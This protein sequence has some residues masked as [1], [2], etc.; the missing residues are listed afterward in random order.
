MSRALLFDFDG[1]LAE[2]LPHHLQAWEKAFRG[3]PFEPHE[4]TIKL[5]EGSKAFQ[6]CM[7]MAKHGGVEISEEK[8]KELAD[9]K[10][11]IFRA[12]NKARLYPEIPKIIS[13]A[14]QHGAK[15][16]LVTGTSLK[17]LQV[18]IPPEIYNLFDTIIAENDTARGKPFPDP[19]LVAIKRL[20]IPADQC[21]VLENAPMGIDS[22][23]AAG[24]FCVA[25]MTT[26]SREHLQRADVIYENHGALLQNMSELFEELPER[27]ND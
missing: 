27:K 24:A 2:T 16:G 26:L 6:I 1:V 23:K 12:A 19:Y 22:A 8:A 5:N 21:I 25:L 4:M 10:N 17:N 20:N 3:E 18:V 9:K 11:D 13:V 14:K 15:I 7:A